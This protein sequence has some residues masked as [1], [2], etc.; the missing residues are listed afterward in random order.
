MNK[1]I[2]RFLKSYL[3]SIVVIS[4][5]LNCLKI[6]T[7]FKESWHCSNSYL[8]IVM[9]GMTLIKQDTFGNKNMK[10]LFCN[11]NRKKWGTGYCKGYSH[12]ITV[13]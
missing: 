12:A 8:F 7:V 13:H 1:H 4:S 11:M 5:F 9:G 3:G 10:T 2:A 6:E